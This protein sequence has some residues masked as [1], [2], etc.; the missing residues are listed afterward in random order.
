[1]LSRKW[2]LTFLTDTPVPAGHKLI[3][4]TFFERAKKGQR[5]STEVV[6]AWIFCENFIILQRRECANATKLTLK[7][8]QLFKHLSSAGSIRELRSLPDCSNVSV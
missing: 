7:T 3:L 5:S 1:M 2:C 8:P 6:W 4:P